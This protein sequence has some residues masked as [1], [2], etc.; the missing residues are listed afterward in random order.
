MPNATVSNFF[1]GGPAIYSAPP[2]FCQ[3]VNGYPAMGPPMMAVPQP[4][5]AKPKG[6]PPHVCVACT[7]ENKCKKCLQKE[8]ES[9]NYVIK[10]S[11]SNPRGSYRP[12]IFSNKVIRSG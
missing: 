4:P 5:P 11:F 3:I 1:F 9:K 10:Q 8:E 7:A 6:P 12:S 2:G